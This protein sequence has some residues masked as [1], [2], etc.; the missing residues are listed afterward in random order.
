MLRHAS[1]RLLSR[2]HQRAREA[3]MRSCSCLCVYVGVR[4]RER[5]RGIYL[6]T[7]FWDAKHRCSAESPCVLQPQS[8][9]SCLQDLFFSD[10]LSRI[11]S[12]SSACLGRSYAK[13][14]FICF[15]HLSIID[16]ASHLLVFDRNQSKKLKPDSI[17]ATCMYVMDRLDKVERQ[18]ASRCH[19]SSLASLGGNVRTH[20][21]SNQT[22]IR[23]LVLAQKTIVAGQNHDEKHK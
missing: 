11:A 14:C 1:V 9:V 2:W 13:P 6:R 22:R 15:A 12:F 16:G 4:E 17:K 23:A 3:C 20:A 21:P 7:M 5:G 18:L 8:F 19:R 10:Y